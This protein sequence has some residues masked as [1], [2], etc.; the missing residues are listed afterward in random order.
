MTRP[1]FTA[2]AGKLQQVFLNLFINAR[3]AMPSGGR[4]DVRTWLEGTR[5]QVEVSDSGSG[6][7]PEHLQKIYDP[8]FLLK[9]AARAQALSLSVSC[10]FIRRAQPVPSRKFSQPV[11]ESGARF[12]IAFPAS[13]IQ[14]GLSLDARASLEV[15]TAPMIS[16]RCATL[17]ASRVLVIDDEPDILKPRNPAG[18]CGLSGR[19]SRPWQ[20]RG[21]H[22]LEARGFPVS[23]LAQF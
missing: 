14:R 19:S 13:A 17:P 16:C 9:A 22:R 8:F 7:A 4:L 11:S 6:I 2:T 3:D 10:I 1:S 21:L 23:D 18:R 12:H 5:A 20:H 15:N